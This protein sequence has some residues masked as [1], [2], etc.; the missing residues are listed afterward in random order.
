MEIFNKFPESFKIA[1]E[2]F[3]KDPTTIKYFPE[4]QRMEITWEK[5]MI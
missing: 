5:A 4:E 3:K 2:S 1:L